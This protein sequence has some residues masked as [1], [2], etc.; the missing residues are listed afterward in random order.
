MKENTLPAL[1]NIDLR[2]NNTKKVIDAVDNV[3]KHFKELKKQNRVNFIIGLSTSLIILLFLGCIVYSVFNT[4]GS[5]IDNIVDRDAMIHRYVCYYYNY[6][7]TFRM[8]S[9]AV[10]FKEL[11]GDNISCRYW[12]IE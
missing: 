11:F 1:D 5:F 12:E 6:N 9:Q 8:A 3:G 4:K 10:D 7:V 2:K